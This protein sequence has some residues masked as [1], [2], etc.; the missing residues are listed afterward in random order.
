MSITGKRKRKMHDLKILEISAVDK[1]AQV[2]AKAAILKRAAGDDELDALFKRRKG[3]SRPAG[4]GPGT[5]RLNTLYRDFLY[6]RTDLTSRAAFGLAWGALTDDERAQVQKE[7]DAHER[8]LQEEKAQLAREAKAETGLR[9]REARTEAA[10]RET[11]KGS[12]MDDF[13]KRMAKEH[14]SAKVG[15]RI[16]KCGNRDPEGGQ[17]L[18][19][20]EYT[21]IITA[22][23]VAKGT[24]FAKLFE[25]KDDDGLTRRRTW[26]LIKTLAATP[27]LAAI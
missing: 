24:T 23:A 9:L 18:S 22:E 21:A 26:Q 4:E 15:E 2:H 19:E 16:L 13:V 8:V 14:G 20:S 6:T 10:T 7:H 1:P 17:A 11:R 12:T 25:A 27:G 3:W 5:T